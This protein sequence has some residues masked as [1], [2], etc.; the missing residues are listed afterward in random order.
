[1]ILKPR[2]I[3]QK[4][5]NHK[6]RSLIILLFLLVCIGGA[7]YVL[8]K[9]TKTVTTM[10]AKVQVAKATYDADLTQ[11]NSSTG[12]LEAIAD[13][14]IKSKVEAPI[15]AIY[16]TKNQ[17]VR[18][19]SLLIELEHNNVTA[20][21]AAANAQIEVNSA[22]EVS[23][24]AQAANAAKEQERYDL[25]ISKGYATQQEVASKR[26]TSKT[27][28]ADYQKA[29]ASLTS[30]QADAQAAQAV[31]EDY[32]LKA[33]FDGIVLDDYGLPVGSKISVDTNVIRIADISS[34]KCLVSFPEK[35]F[36][37]LR[38]GMKATLVCD[39]LPGEKFIGIISKVDQFVDTGSHTFKV[40]V[41]IDN[42]ALDYKLKP[43]FFAKVYVIEKAGNAQTLTIPKAALR[44]GKEVLVIRDKKVYTQEVKT[45]ISDDKTVAIT[46]GLK[47]GDLVVTSGGNSLKD[48]DAVTYD[49]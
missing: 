17:Q 36:S 3:I 45:G 5:K 23:A 18:K 44:N 48:E 41:V 30:S 10:A 12:S 4:I 26:T 20:K 49:E 13:V 38:A 7:H 31:L 25:L 6:H 21:L 37:Q 29:A 22:A 14:V 15:K 1:M 19:G 27:A 32:Y 8:N 46:E 24:K 40:E 28:G 35:L 9:Q 42:A 11:G 47:A 34:I 43:G 2:E 39:S 16:A 33:P